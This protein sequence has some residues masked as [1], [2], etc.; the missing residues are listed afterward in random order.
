MVTAVLSV[1]TASA[2]DNGNGRRNSEVL[3]FG[4]DVQLPDIKPN[5]FMGKYWFCY[6]KE[7]LIDTCYVYIQGSLNKFPDFFRMDTFIDSTH[8]K[9]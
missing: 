2:Q 6:F 9:P 4:S 3:V 1:S 8:M 5:K 7:T